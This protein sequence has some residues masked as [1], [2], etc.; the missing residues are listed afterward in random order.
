LLLDARDG[1]LLWSQEVS[2]EITAPA[3][4]EGLLVVGTDD[5]FVVAFE[6]KG[7]AR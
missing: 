6:Q 4:A 7:V 3:Q 2:D 1:R 5:G